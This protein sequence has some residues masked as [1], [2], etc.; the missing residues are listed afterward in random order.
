VVVYD[1]M[2]GSTDRMARALGEGIA[3]A[4]GAVK[5]MPL[6]SFHRSDVATEILEAGAL[7][8]G[9][10]TINNGVLPTVADVLSYLKGLKPKNL[11]GTAF[12]SFGWSGE[13]VGLIREALDQMKVEPVGEDVKVKYVPDQEALA[14][15]HALGNS[16]A[17]KL[18]EIC[19]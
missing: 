5:L 3:A 11:I 14:R 15:C 18:K 7:L 16:V 8:V 12:G 6:N 1:T 4:G 17:E 9:S 13:A 2:W 10:S 19:S